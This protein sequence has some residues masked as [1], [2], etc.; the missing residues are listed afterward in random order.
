MMIDRAEKAGLGIAFAGHVLLIAILSA[1]VLAVRTPL[2][3]KRQ[4][5]E[6][7]LVDEVGLE[8]G[9]P[10]I[11]QAEPAP[12]LAEVE[13][14]VEPAPPIPQAAQPVPNER[15]APPK[16]APALKPLPKVAPPQARPSGGRL[17]G[18]LSGLSESDSDSR[19]TA[20]PAQTITP[21][22]QSA[23][24]SAVRRQLKPHWRSPSGADVELL[25]T[26]VEVH[27]ARD[28]TIMGDPKVIE[29][30]G[31]NASNRSQAGLHRENAL[32]AV[33]LAAPFVLPPDLYDGWKVIRPAF[34]KRLSQ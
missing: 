29:Q 18:L 16:P 11:S 15:P 5:V 14:P 12:K 25:R 21:N 20:P 33:R 7:Q 28:G 32:K 4:A 10:Q 24:A 27:L 19:A 17:K 30:T 9:A 31:L 6:V 2:A 3:V 26:T 34:D 13:A 22:I 23:L 1:G 8:S